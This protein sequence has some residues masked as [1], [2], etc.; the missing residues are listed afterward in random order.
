[1]SLVKKL[2]NTSPRKQKPNSQLQGERRKP[3][4]SPFSPGKPIR[5]SMPE[6]WFIRHGESETNAGLPSVSDQSTKLTETGKR[7]AEYVAKYLQEYLQ[8]PPDLFVISPYDRTRMTAAP[9]LE[10][11]PSVPVET[12]QIHEYTYLS[13]DQYSGTTT[14]DRRRLSEDYFRIADPDLIL[15][16]GGES[17]KQFI[18]RVDTCFN[19]LIESDFQK[20]I[21]FGHGWFTR[22][23]LWT[24]FTGQGSLPAQAEILEQ[25]RQIMPISWLPLRIF[26]WLRKRRWAKEMHKFLIFS[27]GIQTPNCS[28]LK[29]KHNGV[30]KIDLV[31]Y[32]IN[33]LP[34]DLRKTTL[35]NR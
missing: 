22:A 14:S 1:M 30:D 4:L 9:S 12:W 33:H 28:I 29:F 10:K 26:R 21:L 25:A 31:D 17:F 11:F 35:R 20:V 8:E 16:K 32:K 13:H 27:A 19:R 7:Q 5:G 18:G 23:G 15:G 6:F 24:L 2:K 3:L 34:P